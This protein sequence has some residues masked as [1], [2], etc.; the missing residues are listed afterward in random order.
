MMAAALR[1]ALCVAGAALS[2]YALHVEHEVAKDPS[3]RAA[4]D[5][6]PS[7]SCTR[8][9]SSRLFAYLGTEAWFVRFICIFGH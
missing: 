1:A 2:V 3:Y 6:G 9:F 7:V 8:V 4:C 5:L